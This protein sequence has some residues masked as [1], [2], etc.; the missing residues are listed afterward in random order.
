MDIHK[1]I[2]VLN[3]MILDGIIM[4]EDETKAIETAVYVLPELLHYRKIG[5]VEECRTAMEKQIPK[6]PLKRAV[7]G[8]RLRRELLSCP[9][10]GKRLFDIA[11]LNGKKDHVS[12]KKSKC[13]HNCGQA[14]KWED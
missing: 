7:G 11:Y 3:N 1:A 5:T 12:G 8:E 10:C 4:T 14:L 13:C 6:E 9:I 2:I